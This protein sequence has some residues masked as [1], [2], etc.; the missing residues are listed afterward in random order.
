MTTMDDLIEAGDLDRLAMA[1]KLTG[2]VRRGALA[3]FPNA[4]G[5]LDI[6]WLSGPAGIPPADQVPIPADEDFEAK[7]R[8]YN[9]FVQAHFLIPGPPSE[10]WRDRPPLL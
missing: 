6:A 3:F 5:G 10:S 4:D 2:P 9:E 7:R 8:K 1:L